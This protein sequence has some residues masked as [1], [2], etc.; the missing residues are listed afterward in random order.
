LPTHHPQIMVAKV[1]ENDYD[2]VAGQINELIALSAKND[3]MAVV[4]KMKDIVPEFLSN[5]SVFEKLDKPTLKEK[6]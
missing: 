6:V 4:Q 2:T 3:D 5:N 1:K